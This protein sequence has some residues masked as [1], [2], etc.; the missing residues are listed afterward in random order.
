MPVTPA[1]PPSKVRT[2]LLQTDG[3]GI[4][5]APATSA[6]TAQGPAFIPG[7]SA[8]LQLLGAD[9]AAFSFT[10]GGP[11]PT[12]T[13][14]NLPYRDN[15]VNPLAGTQTASPSLTVAPKDHL[16]FVAFLQGLVAP[17]GTVVGVTPQATDANNLVLQGPFLGANTFQSF[18]VALAVSSSTAGTVSGMVVA[19][20][21]L[22]VG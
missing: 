5:L 13:F 1:R 9:A 16:I 15:T 2:P 7:S 21:L 10:A 11:V 6:A 20:L 14:P 19:L 12:L 4:A 22:S 3:G 8:T 18:G 17:A